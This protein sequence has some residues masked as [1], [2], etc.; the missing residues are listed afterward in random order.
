MHLLAVAHATTNN[1]YGW[2]FRIIFAVIAVMVVGAILR[3]AIGWGP[4]RKTTLPVSQA[5][6]ARG[7]KA[8]GRAARRAG[9]TAPAAR[10]EDAV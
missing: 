5:P 1:D 8:V 2:L 10:P 6:A 4:T 3:F 9:K 7:A